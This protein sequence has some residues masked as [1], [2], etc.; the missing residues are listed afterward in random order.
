MAHK[1]V[2]LINNYEIT[3]LAYKHLFNVALTSITSGIFER[4]TRVD[5]RKNS[6]EAAL[7]L[8]KKCKCKHIIDHGKFGIYFICEDLDGLYKFIETEQKGNMTVRVSLWKLFR[9]I[10]IKREQNRAKIYLFGIPLFYV[11]FDKK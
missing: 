5:L 7:E 6:L 2:E 3:E 11:F 8:Y 4:T 9:F 1:I 10:K